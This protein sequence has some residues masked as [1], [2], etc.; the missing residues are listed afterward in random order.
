MLEGT[1]AINDAIAADVTIDD[2][3]VSVDEED[4]PVVPQDVPTHRVGRQ[5]LKALSDTVTPQ[6]MVAVARTPLVELEELRS[7]NFAL[8]LDAVADPGNAGTLI[9]TGVAA[10]ADAIVFTTGSVDAFSPKVVRAAAA[11]LFATKL[12]TDVAFETAIAIAREGGSRIVATAS[13]ATPYYE[14]DLTGSLVLVAGNEAWG[15]SDEHLDL[16]DVTVGIPMSDG[17]ESLNVAVATGIV[18]FEA[19]RQ[20]RLSSAPGRNEGA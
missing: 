15:M 14:V 19:V 6:G 16:C 9:R 10:G 5:V 13:G 11:S 1:R 2:L 4:G 18:A 17:T 8:I 20:R 3:F 7:S 12:I